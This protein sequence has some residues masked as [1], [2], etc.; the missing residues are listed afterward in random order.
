M[1]RDWGGVQDMERLF[2]TQTEQPEIGEAW[3]P[4][5]FEAQEHAARILLNR[6]ANGDVLIPA[7]G[8]TPRNALHEA[9]NRGYVRIVKLL[10]EKGANPSVVEPR[11]N[12]T[13]AGWAEHGGHS[14][15]AELVHQF[16]AIRSE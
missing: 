3:C 16:G 12:G 5:P 6:G 1:Q 11:W 14:E 2:Q 8:Q 13:P 4:H 15:I 10:L 7:G 9:S